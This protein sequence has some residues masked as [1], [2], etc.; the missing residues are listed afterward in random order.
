MFWKW[1][2][3]LNMIL[4]VLKVSTPKSRLWFYDARAG[5][6]LALWP[7]SWSINQNRNQFSS[8]FAIYYYSNEQ[9]RYKHVHKLPQKDL[10][11]R[12]QETCIVFF[13]GVGN[14][15]KG[16]HELNLLYS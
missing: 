8:W 14:L 5:N 15:L 3:M 16:K 13:Y 1:P 11:L 12:Q 2:F 4:E 7:T 9:F 6:T 10:Q